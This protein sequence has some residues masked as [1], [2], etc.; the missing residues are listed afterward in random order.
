MT[1]YIIEWSGIGARIVELIG[2]VPTCLI[3]KRIREERLR[4][5]IV[6][7][8]DCRFS[9]VFDGKRYPGKKYKGKTYCINWG[10]GMQGEWTK[11]DGYC[12]RAKR[13]EGGD[14]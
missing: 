5:E 8:R 6:R 13:K 9:R 10:D 4:E 2:S 14:D 12:H 7:C 1:E 3:T 11:P